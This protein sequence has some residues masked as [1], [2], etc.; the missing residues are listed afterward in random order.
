MDTICFGEI[1]WD[2]LP[3]RTMPG[4]AP[5]NVCYHLNKMG[6]QAALVSKIGKD[7]NGADLVHF[8][9]ENSIPTALLQEDNNN[10][11][12]T[13][14]ATQMD[15]EMHYEI[16]APVAWD[17]IEASS[18]LVKKVAEASYFVCGSLAA[19]N[20]TTKNTLLQLLDVAQ[21]KVIDINLRAPYYNQ[22][23]IEALLK[24]AN[25][26][27]LNH[28]ELD[29]ISKWYS[30]EVNLERQMQLL[31]DK[32]SISVII[33]TRGSDGA[34]LMEANKLYYH[35]GFTLK[36]ND[37]I[38]CG[39]A[40]LA[41]FL[42]KRIVGEVAESALNFACQTGAFIATQQGGCPAYNIND[43]ERISH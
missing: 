5:M 7:K 6:V 42:S 36:I 20:E 9:Q 43:I 23:T 29:L 3:H 35:Q 33:V 25:I 4:G 14:T 38:G 24:H 12:G 26:L 41:G 18:T 39:D 31:K 34:V 8:L 28:H 19:R 13:V 10:P 17:F 37:S 32:F 21:T 1:L 2:I 16:V 40:F 15:D 30:H 22:P 11:T 27:K